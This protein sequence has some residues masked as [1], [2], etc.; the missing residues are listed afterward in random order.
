MAIPNCLLSSAQNWAPQNEGPPAPRGQLERTHRSYSLPCISHQIRLIP[1]AATQQNQP[2][3]FSKTATPPPFLWL[4]KLRVSSPRSTLLSAVTQ[5]LCWA[6]DPSQNYSCSTG[7][8][9]AS[10]P[11]KGRGAPPP[12]LSPSQTVPSLLKDCFGPRP[13]SP[14]SSWGSP[15]WLQGG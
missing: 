3:S 9:Q 4:E 8:T 7:G 11:A 2:W 6:W 15:K 10:S 1:L 12:A 14:A 13:H 5:L